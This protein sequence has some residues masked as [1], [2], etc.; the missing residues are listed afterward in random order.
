ML[1]LDFTPS[2][3]PPAA[4]RLALATALSIGLSLLADAGLVAIGTRVFPS[5]KG[6][7]HFQ[8]QDYAK[9]TIIGIVIA[10]AAWP[11]VIRVSSSPRWLFFRAAIV[12]TAVLLLP[13]VYIWHQGQPARAV[14][15]LMLMHL[16]IGVITYN[17]L[18][19]LAPP[20]KRTPTPAVRGATPA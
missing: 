19:H 7:G 11:I 13:D 14:L 3:R 12:V 8:F 10:C 18:V 20:R 15:F 6:Y 4:V 17:V 16:A 9:L 5:T 2:A 1:H